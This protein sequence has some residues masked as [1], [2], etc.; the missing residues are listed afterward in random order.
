MEDDLFFKCPVEY[1]GWSEGLLIDFF[2]KTISNCNPHN[3][4]IQQLITWISKGKPNTNAFDEE[5][6]YREFL[7]NIYEAIKD[8]RT[9]SNG[10]M[11]PN[12]FALFIQ[13]IDVELSWMLVRQRSIYNLTIYDYVAVK[14]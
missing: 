7:H 6:V 8:Y 14:F 5:L 3:N 10:N 9:N 11:Y 4:D 1:R 2:I 13:F 12:A